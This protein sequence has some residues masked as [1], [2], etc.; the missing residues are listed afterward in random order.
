[1][2]VHIAA[3]RP[4]SRTFPEFAK[5]KRPFGWTLSLP[6]LS[7]AARKAIYCVTVCIVSQVRTVR[8]GD[9]STDR[10]PCA[11]TARRRVYCRER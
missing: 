9:E 6:E 1:M 7:L 4:L 3:G 10:E 11:V 5:L 2:P 8:P